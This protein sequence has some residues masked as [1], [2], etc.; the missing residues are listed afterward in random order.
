MIRRTR[1]AI[2]ARAMLALALI[3]YSLPGW[4][5]PPPGVLLPDYQ[6]YNFGD[7]A[8]RDTARISISLLVNP[9][10]GSTETWFISDRPPTFYSNQEG[11]FAVDFARTTCTPG[12]IVTTTSGCSV[13]VTF[14]P[15][16][17]GPK[18]AVWLSI[19]LCRS[20]FPCPTSTF[21]GSTLNFVGSTPVSAIPT[22]SSTGILLLVL[23]VLAIAVR[24]LRR[25][26]P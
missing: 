9:L 19:T 16:S 3:G 13:T 14:T 2:I 15:T 11:S 20:T 10:G 23:L 1:N 6:T 12:L 22:V 24:R 4:C 25:G 7:V 17:P 18:S 5:P 26:V 21:Q 8:L